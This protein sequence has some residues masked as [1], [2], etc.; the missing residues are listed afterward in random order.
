MGDVSADS[1]RIGCPLTMTNRTKLF[2]CRFYTCFF[3]HDFLNLGL[4]IK[5]F[6][7]LDQ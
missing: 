2:K 5:R 6:P 4:E 7:E 3:E 1:T